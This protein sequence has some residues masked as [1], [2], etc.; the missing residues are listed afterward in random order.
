[1]RVAVIGRNVSAALWVRSLLAAGVYEVLWLQTEADRGARD[2]DPTLLRFGRSLPLPGEE[3]AQDFFVFHRGDRR[4]PLT[5]FVAGGSLWGEIRDLPACVT[6]QLLARGIGSDLTPRLWRSGPAGT[7]VPDPDWIHRLPLSLEGTAAGAPVPRRVSRKSALEAFEAEAKAKGA[8]LCAP[9]QTVLGLRVGG[10]G[11]RH[12]ITFNAPFSYEEVDALLWASAVDRPKEEASA[13]ALLRTRPW[14]DTAGRW[15]VG[16]A[17]VD[18]GLL[19]GLPESSLWIL[20]ELP[21]TGQLLNGQL[22]RV[23]RRKEK[24]GRSKLQ[25]E[26]LVLRDEPWAAPARPDE[27]LWSLLPALGRASLSFQPVVCDEFVFFA[28][29]KPRLVELASRIAFW[30]PGSLGREDEALNSWLKQPKPAPAPA[31]APPKES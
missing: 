1:M 17:V 27:F 22:A 18:S 10:R 31:V 16:E 8:F 3:T 29:P 19:A 30:S 24:S 26:R 20:G 7:R 28:D 23:H 4:D 2:S 15:V 6:R 5:D 12:Q 9:D 14:N 13:D 11:S 21:S 25:V